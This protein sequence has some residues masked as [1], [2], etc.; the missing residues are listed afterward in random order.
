MCDCE[1]NE[2]VKNEHIQNRPTNLCANEDYGEQQEWTMQTATTTKPKRNTLT[3][4][5]LK[6]PCIGN[7]RPV[8]WLY[9]VGWEIIWWVREVWYQ[10][11]TW[12]RFK[13][14]YEKER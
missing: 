4:W 13:R 1:K 8:K 7:S 14:Q 5:L 6:H 9:V 10:H 2:H 12:L 11:V 3:C